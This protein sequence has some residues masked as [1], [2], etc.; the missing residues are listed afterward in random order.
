MDR[1]VTACAAASACVHIGQARHRRGCADRPGTDAAAGSRRAPLGA[2]RAGHL[3]RTWPGNDFV[4]SVVH[5]CSLAD[6][7]RALGGFVWP[8]LA[9]GLPLPVRPTRCT[10]LQ[11]V[12][13]PIV[14]LREL[15]MGARRYVETLE[16]TMV[17]VL[18]SYGLHA[19]V[20]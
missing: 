18:G 2:R 1:I 17:L 10:M 20:R 5:T 14:S 15:G 3:P 4:L 11:V 16:D 13:Y 19:R 9:S 7:R 6:L 8:P 12:L